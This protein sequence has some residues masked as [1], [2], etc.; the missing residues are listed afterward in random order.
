MT[1]V[2]GDFKQDKYDRIAVDIKSVILDHAKENHL[3]LV[4]AVGIL[5][6]V[7]MELYAEQ[8]ESEFH[9]DEW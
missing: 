5:E 2:V 8:V 3:S 4:E 7:K 1:V 9:D 6:L